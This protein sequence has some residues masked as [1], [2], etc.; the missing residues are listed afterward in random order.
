M[1]NLDSGLVVETMVYHDQGADETWISSDLA[2]RLA[3]RPIAKTDCSITTVTGVETYK[4]TPIVDVRLQSL[5]KSTSQKLRCR[6][7]DDIPKDCSYK[8]LAKFKKKYSY[9]DKVQLHTTTET[10]VGLCIGRDNC[11]LLNHE[12]IVEGK[13]VLLDF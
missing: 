4:N 11:H 10:E 3:L 2:N 6:V 1:K 12:E 13:I 5:D 9:L 7:M 8:N